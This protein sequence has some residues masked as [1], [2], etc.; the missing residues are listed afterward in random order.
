MSA[1][2]TLVSGT[3]SEE[4]LESSDLSISGNN[5]LSGWL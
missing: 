3:K 1:S 5:S 4:L 2:V